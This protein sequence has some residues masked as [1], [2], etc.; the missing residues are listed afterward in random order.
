MTK[1]QARTFALGAFMAALSVWAVLRFS[2]P[3]VAAC[4]VLPVP[5]GAVTQTVSVPAT[6]TYTIWSRINAPDATA[7]SYYLEI[8]GTIC[9]VVVGDGALAANTWAWVNYQSGNTNSKITVNLTAGSH[10]VRM[11]GRETGVK[12][13]RVVMTADTA[14]VPSGFGDNC[15]SPPTDTTVPTVSLTAPVSGQILAGTF[16]I[17][18][19]ASDNVGVARVEFLIDNQVAHTDTVAPYVMDWNTTTV[20]NGAHSITA[21]AYDAEN[22]TGTITRNITVSNQTLPPAFKAEDINQDGRVNLLDFSLLASKYGQQGSGLGR[23]DINIDGRVNLLDFSL[24]AAQ[25]GT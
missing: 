13:D 24:L 5:N 11:A 23:A 21:K 7:N 20:S 15:A 12:L 6:A 8:D 4:P 1:T 14:C 17:L 2:M 16:T 9:G 18:A 3:A 10:T 19:G 25:F 22:N